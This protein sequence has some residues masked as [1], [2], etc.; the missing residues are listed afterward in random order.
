MPTKVANFRTTTSVYK[1]TVYQWTMQVPT[2]LQKRLG[3]VRLF[4]TLPPDRA[5]A[6]RRAEQLNQQHRAL[7]A[8]LRDPQHTGT[9]DAKT[10]LDAYNVPQRQLSPTELYHLPPQLEAQFDRYETVDEM[11]LPL[12]KALDTITGQNSKSISVAMKFYAEV[13]ANIVKP[14][15][16]KA[17]QRYTDEFIEIVGDLELG[18]IKRDHVR[19]YVSALLA[20]GLKPSTV[21]IAVVRLGAIVHHY[22]VEKDLSGV[23]NPFQSFQVA[24]TADT[25]SDRRPYTASEFKSLIALTETP[26]TGKED[27]QLAIQLIATTGARM[28]E[29]VGLRLDDVIVTPTGLALN[30][31]DNDTRTLKTKH[32]RR[33]VPIVH[34]ASMGG[35]HQRMAQTQ[36]DKE[37]YL[38]PRW[39]DR[40]A[41][42]SAN[43]VR[44]VDA[45]VPK[46]QSITGTRVALH[47]LR[48][49]VAQ[50][51]KD[52]QAPIEAI[53][54]LLGWSG[55]GMASHYG[56]ELA[57]SVK[58]EWMSKAVTQL[59]D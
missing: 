13:K 28:G 43:C 18:E 36:A 26:I 19:T 20:R 16:I 42:F 14:H 41:Q 50:A 38:F 33:T 34:W 53:N 5:S 44:L 40:H 39:K 47:S 59:L 56:G 7:F 6:L 12:R 3:K 32:S 15:V 2:D 57:M 46:D 45:K 27:L 1:G 48:H 25:E 54:S 21:K 35:L 22:V 23:S 9:V 31:F 55:K 17:T 8:L 4:E 51:L 52:V 49:T 58:R 11:P 29:I 10:I 30:L 24:K 37:T